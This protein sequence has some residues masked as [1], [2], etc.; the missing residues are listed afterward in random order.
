MSGLNRSKIKILSL[1]FLQ[2]DWIVLKRC[3]IQLEDLILMKIKRFTL[4]TGKLMEIMLLE[5]KK[6]E[7]MNGNSILKSIDSDI[8]KKGF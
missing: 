4:C 2:Q 6:Q 5:S 1:D 8:V 3:Y 7:I